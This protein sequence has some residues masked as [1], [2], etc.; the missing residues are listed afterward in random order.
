MYSVS[1]QDLTK[2]NSMKFTKFFL[3]IVFSL[4]SSHSFSNED[5]NDLELPFLNMDFE[6]DSSRSGFPQLPPRINRV[7]QPHDIGQVILYQTGFLT[8]PSRFGDTARPLSLHNRSSGQQL[9]N[10]SSA[11]YERGRTQTERRTLPM[12]SENLGGFFLQSPIERLF[13]E[14]NQ[15]MISIYSHESSSLDFNAMNVLDDLKVQFE[16]R[17]FE[18]CRDLIAV[19]RGMINPAGVERSS[20]YIRLLVKMN[21]NLEILDARIESMILQM[22]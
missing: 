14:Q 13:E 9:N 5:I 21:L 18:N 7:V 20:T 2:R 16:R 12:S 11:G 8:P 10:F 1:R 6:Y 4:I 17:N 15:L 22:N 3:F 19:L